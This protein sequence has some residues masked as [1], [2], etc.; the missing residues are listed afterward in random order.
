MKKLTDELMISETEGDTIDII[1][2]PDKTPEAYER[3]VRCMM[4]SGLSREEA[5]GYVLGTPLPMEFFYDI[6]RGLFAV[7]SEAVT[8]TPVYNP[9]TGREIPE[10][11]ETEQE[12]PE[13]LNEEQLKKDGWECTD[14]DTGQWGRKINDFTWEY[15]DNGDG[16]EDAI[17]INLRHYTIAQIE[18]AIQTYGYS[19]VPGVEFIYKQCDDS[20]LQIIAECLFELGE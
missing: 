6:G 17:T 19:L 8:N 14:P 18:D 12:T 16:P 4:T 11:E 3:K 10:Q 2:S 15:F 13:K 9:Y 20:F 5:E 7:E 1:L